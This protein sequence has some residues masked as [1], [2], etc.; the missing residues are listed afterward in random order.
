MEELSRVKPAVF[1]ADSTIVMQDGRTL[2][3][4]VRRRFA[5]LPLILLNRF[6]ADVVNRFRFLGDM[7]VLGEPVDGVALLRHVRARCSASWMSRV[8]LHPAFDPMEIDHCG[9]I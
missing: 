5:A 6:P 8:V 7:A 9:V 3:E 4:S 1:I 2:A